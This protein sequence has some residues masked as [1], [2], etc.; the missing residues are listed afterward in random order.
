[1]TMATSYLFFIVSLAA[2]V[3]AVAVAVLAW[4]VL[5]MRKRMNAIF[6]GAHSSGELADHMLQRMARAEAMLE[7]I[8]PRLGVLEHTAET[9]LRKV[10]FLRFNP[11]Q[12]TGG[13]N[14]FVIVLLDGEDNGVMMSSLYMRDGTRL[15]AKSVERGAVRS[16]LSEEEQGVLDDAMR[17]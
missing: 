13:D 14:S 17:K 6:G 5:A 7:E 2:L 9:T 10:G 15:Y 8:E 11:F 3:M 4:M 16:S 12:D 1:M